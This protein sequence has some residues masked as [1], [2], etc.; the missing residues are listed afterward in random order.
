MTE[1][2]LPPVPTL[3]SNTISRK[4]HQVGVPLE[5]G[6]EKMSSGLGEGVAGN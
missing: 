2:I 3:V 4:G 6:I 1:N 5:V